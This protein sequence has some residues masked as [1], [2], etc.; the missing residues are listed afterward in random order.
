[1]IVRDQYQALS[2]AV[3]MEARAIRTYER[4]LTLATKPEVQEGIRAILREE[5][6]HY[7][8]FSEMRGSITADMAAEDKLLTGAMA[9]ETLFP[10]GAMELARAKGLTSMRGLF[11]FA[12]E[13]EQDAVEKYKS[14]AD[15]CA[16]AEIAEAFLDIAREEATHLQNLRR[17]LARLPEENA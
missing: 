5:R 1:M 3:E 16:N 6:E 10:G 4:A 9:G 11:E 13:S 17:V 2:V 15:Q 8:C 7:R 12:A 14:F